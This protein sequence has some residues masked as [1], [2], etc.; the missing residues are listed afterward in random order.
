[1]QWATVA[2]QAAADA[3]G[4]LYPISDIRKIDTLIK[5]STSEMKARLT[6][7]KKIADNMRH[8]R[9]DGNCF[10]RALGFSFL[11]L[12]SSKDEEST[13]GDIMD[14]DSKGLAAMMSDLKIKDPLE[15]EKVPE[16]RKGS[17]E[18]DEEKSKENKFVGTRWQL[19][20]LTLSHARKGEKWHPRE[21]TRK[22]S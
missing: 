10:Y 18:V 6:E 15:E 17:E 2:K 22:K 13:G 1:M 7:I 12:G 8:V 19:L 9:G 4:V 3:E 14:V 5:V 21:R 16:K 11:E 20:V